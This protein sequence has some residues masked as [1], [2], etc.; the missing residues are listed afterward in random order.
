M[1]GVL[2]KR[3]QFCPQVNTS[4]GHVAVTARAPR[5]DVEAVQDGD[6]SSNKKGFRGLSLRRRS[7]FRK[8][9]T[10]EVPV[11]ANA[12]DRAGIT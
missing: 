5:S 2:Q 8:Q 11:H 1:T 10:V 7:V 9:R 3:Y 6:E 4:R 12:K